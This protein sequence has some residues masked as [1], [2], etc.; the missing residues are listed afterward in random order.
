LDL[1]DTALSA[2][3]TSLQHIE[4]RL[5]DGDKTIEQDFNYCM[6]GLIDGRAQQEQQAGRNA[7]SHY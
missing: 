4:T 1:P 6:S 3:V 7:S 2:M 5:V